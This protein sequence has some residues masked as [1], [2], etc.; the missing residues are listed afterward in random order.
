MNS[1]LDP[2]RL[3]FVNLQTGEEVSARFNPTAFTRTIQV[4]WKE[5]EVLGQSHRPMDYLGTG[6]MSVPLELY[7]RAESLS[8]QQ[9]L[10]NRIAFLE[11]LCYAPE[12]ADSI[13]GRRPPRVLVVWPNTMSFT[14]VITSFACAHQMFDNTGRTIQWTVSIILSEA[15]RNR[16]TQQQ[17]RTRG[18][19]RANN[20]TGGE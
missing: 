6:N 14:A 10:E 15:R 11:S 4:L 8:E 13:A 19:F 7:F 3:Y 12:Q 9:D 5:H 1:S 16:L 17:V 20:N 18:S 2:R